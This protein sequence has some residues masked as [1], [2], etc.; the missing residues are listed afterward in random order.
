MRRH[1]RH[2]LR[3]SEWEWA[4]KHLSP[5]E[6]ALYRE[7]DRIEARL[8]L[9]AQLIDARKHAGHWGQGFERSSSRLSAAVSPG[10]SWTRLTG[11]L[12]ELLAERVEPRYDEDSPWPQGRSRTCG[13]CL[14]ES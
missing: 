2:E 1:P 4:A 12:E 8:G 10:R 9:G 7:L 5:D 6:L 3:P 13:L 14:L 11:K